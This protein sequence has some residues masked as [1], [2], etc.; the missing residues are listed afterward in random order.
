MGKQKKVRKYAEVKRILNPKDVK[1]YAPVLVAYSSL[2]FGLYAAALSDHRQHIILC[3]PSKKPEK[4]TDQQ[5][6]HV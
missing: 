3:R 5:V 4:P 2:P 1:P 6:R